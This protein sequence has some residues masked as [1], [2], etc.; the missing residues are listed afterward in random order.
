M[1][2]TDGA[3]SQ[4]HDDESLQLKLASEKATYRQSIAES[5]KAE[6]EASSS[7]VRSLIPSPE[8]VPTGEVVLGENAGA[9][10]PWRAH[11]LLGEM[12]SQIVE[13]VADKL[14][15]TKI[16]ATTARHGR[17]TN[18][19]VDASQDTVAH[20]GETTPT[21]G[22]PADQAEAGSRVLVTDQPGLLQGDLVA[23]Q[24]DMALR[25]MAAKLL[26]LRAGISSW[27]TEVTD[28]VNTYEAEE[29][30]RGGTRYASLSPRAGE[31]VLGTTEAKLSDVPAPG[32]ALPGV[33]GGALATAVDLLGYLRTD[34][35]VT[36]I[37]V[38]PGASELVVLVAGGLAGKSVATELE[39]T[40]TAAQ[41]PALAALANT[42]RDRDE[43]AALLGGLQSHIA[44]VT[45]E[46]ATLE[47]TAAALEK[48]WIESVSDVDADP[49]PLGGALDDL[50]PRI[51]A[52]SQAIRSVTA[53]ISHSQAALGE[54]DNGLA[55]LTTSDADG[56]TPL[57][58]AVRWGRLGERISH[59]LYVNTE[60]LAADAVTRKSLLG[61]SG[62][63]KYVA[64]G[65]T[66]WLLLDVTSQCVEA[67]GGAEKHDVLTFS[68]ETGIV[69]ASPAPT[70][71]LLTMEEKAK[72]LVLVLIVVL[73]VFALAAIL[74]V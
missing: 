65:N 4:L 10:G 58:T 36:A 5:Q 63:L 49:S 22:L 7:L 26:D 39:S 32:V 45:A 13:T 66:T 11:M 72:Q 71:P 35:A 70:D 68:L 53:F 16:P 61:T 43:V 73:V 30:A 56:E 19:Y 12:A 60:S 9:L 18:P 24:V 54:V 2:E 48:A 52:R 28:A 17:T 55:R 33:A 51:R 67:G 57:S 8:G 1:P 37:T 44:P 40:S 14:H 38:A 46:L 34:Y 3:S 74:G 50:Q 23:R 31:T 47:A 69:E 64:S 62:L 15:T 27:A 41:S 20:H 25:R 42:L 21:P 59:V 29:A 6:A